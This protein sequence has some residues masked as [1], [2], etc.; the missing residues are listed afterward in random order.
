MNSILLLPAPRQPLLLPA[1]KPTV[2]WRLSGY[3]ANGHNSCYLC[4][5][6]IKREFHVQ[7][8]TGEHRVVGSECIDTLLSPDERNKVELFKRRASRAAKQWKDNLPVRRENE[9]REQYISR[10]LAEMP[11]ARRAYNAYLAKSTEITANHTRMF[12]ECDERLKALFK[13]RSATNR[14]YDNLIQK[15]YFDA[16]NQILLDIEKNFTANRFD[17]VRAPWEVRKI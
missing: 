15:V 8:N 9:T 17:F 13:V 7:S 4:G 14:E 1:P 10:R 5:H 2:T 11:N 3:N 12:R 6:D 16:S